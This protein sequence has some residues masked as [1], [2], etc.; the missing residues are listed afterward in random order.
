M[1]I[2]DLLASSAA[3]EPH[4]A[5]IR[6]GDIEISYGQMASL[7]SSLSKRL[8]AIGCTGGVKVAVVLDNS[9]EYIVSFF[10]ISAAAGTIVPLSGHM[11]PHEIAGYIYRA[12][13]SIV[14]TN[15]VLWQRIFDKLNCRDRLTVMCIEYQVEGGLQLQVSRIGDYDVDEQNSDVALMVPTSGTT[16]AP[17]IVM[18]TDHNLISNMS[19]YRSLMGFEG[20]NVAYC[21]LSLHHIYCICAQVLTHVSLADTFVISNKPFFAKD[22]LRAVETHKVTVTAFV[23][24]M[25][26]LFAQYPEPYMFKTESLRCVTLSG[27][28]TPR[29]TCELLADKY[30]TVQFIST[31]GMSEAGSRISIAMP[32]SGRFPIESVGRPMPGVTVRV[33]DQTGNDV[34]PN[35]SG[36]ILV[37]SSGVMKGYYMQPHLTDETV[38]NGWLKTGDIGK[39]DKDGNLFILGRMT[40]TII[41]G[42][43]NVCPMEIEEC[44]I[45]HPAIRE[46]AVIGQQHK[47]LQEVPFA[48]IVKN[49]SNERLTPTDIVKYCKDR[50]SNH[51]IPRSIRFLEKLP[52]LSTCKIDRKALKSM[53]DSLR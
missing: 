33:I 11:A 19:T 21:A 6:T 14:I 39:L 52:K 36:E 51:K 35:S 12:N 26:I 30:H 20:H 38:V 46:V 9:V 25:A 1:K 17:K 13:V 5:A 44:L 4:R 29:S 31:Y 3:A 37:R 45:A 18:L 16:G 2:I 22:F 49:G 24:Y 48:F 27:A 40:D 8:K 23:P 15:K 53:A 41:T 7:V 34:Q 50:L 32:S 43:E 47:L 10:A 42:G 28:K